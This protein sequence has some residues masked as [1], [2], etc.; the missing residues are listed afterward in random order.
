MELH[1]TGETFLIKPRHLEQTGMRASDLPAATRS[2]GTSSS[3]PAESGGSGGG[4]S[5]WQR[6]WSEEHQAHYYHNTRTGDT[7]WEE[8]PGYAP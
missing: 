6:F 8:P 2:R 1:E 5:E 4:G 7:T 3:S